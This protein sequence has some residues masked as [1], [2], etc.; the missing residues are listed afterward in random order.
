VEVEAQISMLIYI[1]Q[2]SLLCFRGGQ[3]DI[4]RGHDEGKNRLKL[5]SHE[6]ESEKELGI[7]PSSNGQEAC[8]T[9]ER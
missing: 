7:F 4:R 1:P 6:K 9:K 5:P 8:I 3:K 2:F